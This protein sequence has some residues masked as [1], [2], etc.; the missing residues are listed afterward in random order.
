MDV[1][2]RDGSMDKK[3]GWVD[4]PVNRLMDGYEDR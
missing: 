3:D 1:W 4:G 2:V